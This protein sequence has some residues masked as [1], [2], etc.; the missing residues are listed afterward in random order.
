MRRLHN[1]VKKPGQ[2]G[3]VSGVERDAVTSQHGA[4][5]ASVRLVEFYQPSVSQNFIPPQP[6]PKERGNAL[7]L[8]NWRAA[9]RIQAKLDRNE[10]CRCK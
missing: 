8:C 6:I 5:G 10:A 1:P 9:A 2:F 4:A 7:T 3:P